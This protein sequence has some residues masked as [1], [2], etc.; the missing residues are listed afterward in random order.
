MSGQCEYQNA[1]VDRL[2]TPADVQHQVPPGWVVCGH[3]ITLPNGE[4]SYLLK[5]PAK[6]PLAGD[7]DKRQPIRRRLRHP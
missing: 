5:R 6:A 7:Q 3:P 4:L 1:V 2:M